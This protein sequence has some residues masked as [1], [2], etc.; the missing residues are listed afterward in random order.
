MTLI[1]YIMLWLQN[2]ALESS[3]YVIHCLFFQK[4]SVKCYRRTRTYAFESFHVN[5]IRNN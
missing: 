1:T 2:I 4:K 3:K 5:P